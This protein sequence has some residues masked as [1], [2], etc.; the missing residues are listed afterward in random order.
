MD[1]VAR[2]N[3]VEHFENLTDPRIDRTKK[4]LLIDIITIT[5]VATI[6]GADGYDEIA[7]FGAARQPWFAQFL[8]LPN[9]TPSHDTFARVF[10]HL[11]PEEF[12]RCFLAW[13]SSL[14]KKTLGRVI[15]M[16]GK[17]LRRSSDI[18]QGLPAIHMVSA[19]ASDNSIVLGQ[20]KVDEKS[21]EITAIPALLEL[22]DI[23]GAI[24]TIDAMGT[25]KT[26]AQQI[27]AQRGDYV[28][29]LKDN[30][31]N[32]KADVEA[33]LERVIK[34]HFRDHEDNKIEHTTSKTRNNDH[35]RLETRTCWA[36]YCPEW[37]QGYKEWANLRSIAV[38]ESQRQIDGKTSTERRYYISSLEPDAKTIGNA[39][40]SHWGIE[41]GL[42]WV[43][44]TAFRE[45]ESR[46]RK[47]NSPQNMAVIRHIAL[48]MLKAEKTMKRSIRR[49]RF[50][51]AIDQEYL[52]N[53]VF[54]EIN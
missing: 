13:T 32:L 25:Q 16:D 29:S 20:I 14:S 39:V 27:V 41:N 22:L 44:D 33:H 50:L 23:E 53:V 18:A 43:L 8:Q 24:I 54:P 31:P 4:H 7:D 3:I 37:V 45:D 15:A 12:S 40:R 52:Q 1:S 26:I 49:K 9:G 48:N 51:A 35:G 36:V 10:A 21:N 28:L 19:W 17:T 2:T 46:I 38:V 6:C 5:L 47:D 34:E 11:N 30:Q 42:H